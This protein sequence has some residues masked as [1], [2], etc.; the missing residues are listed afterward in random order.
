M[1]PDQAAT[2]RGGV[3]G[4]N[5]RLGNQRGEVAVVGAGIVGVS[6]ALYLQ[7]AGFRVTVVDGS[8]PRR[9][10]SFGNAGVLATVNR[11]P[12]GTPSVWRNLPRMLLD[13]TSPLA[14][15]WQYLPRMLPWILHFRRASRPAEVERI[16]R[17]LSTLMER[18]HDGYGPLLTAAGAEHL[19]ERRGWLHLFET[20]ASFAQAQYDIALRRAC[21]VAMD[22]LETD[23]I[24]AFE[25]GLRKDF[26]RGVYYPDPA[27]TVDPNG[28][29]EAFLQRFIADGGRFE[30]REVTGIEVSDDSHVTLR[31]GGETL[32]TERVV[33]AAGAWSRDLVAQ[34]GLRVP[35]DTE[36]GYHV[37]LP[38]SGVE[39]RHPL[40]LF[41]RK[42]AIT[43]MRGGL[44]LAGTVE[45]AG[46]KAGPDAARTR[47]MLEQVR[48]VFPGIGEEGA[49]EW[50]GFRP[51]MP[52]SL[53]VIGRSP[54]HR[55]VFYAFGHGHLG[56]TLGPITGRIIA[57]LASGAPPE[58]D[59]APFDAGRFGRNGAAG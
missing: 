50:L 11:V 34:T 40:V 20:E 17:S 59:I 5:A 30:R 2:A 27:H 4:M 15:R 47:T 39:L 25:P 22:I 28:L 49:T 16:A 43:P 3:G 44:R 21:G 31:T 1:V 45:F 26:H 18:A 56:I 48:K 10:A 33:I 24:R 36:R 14:I 13:R 8:E 12:L 55:S 51:S 29:V 35:L 9:K 54:R 46:L 32:S 6:C 42:F 52:D 53:P 7:R 37:M 19:M 57:D 23:A 58:I 41:D 38:H